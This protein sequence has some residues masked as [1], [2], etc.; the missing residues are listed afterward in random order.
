MR[1]YKMA[2]FHMT[3]QTQTVTLMGTN[4][5]DNTCKEIM[6]LPLSITW[7]R[8]GKHEYIKPTDPRRTL[9]V[10]YAPFIKV[11][12]YTHKTRLYIVILYQ[13]AY[14]WKLAIHSLITPHAENGTQQRMYYYL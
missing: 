2:C 3:T 12:H 8:S 10:L 13:H 6:Y 5:Y 4:D 14:V 11:L 1:V 9:R 7:Q